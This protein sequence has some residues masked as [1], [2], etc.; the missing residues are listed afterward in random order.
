V[1]IDKI[2]VESVSIFKTKSDPPIRSEYP[3]TAENAEKSQPPR[4]G[5][6]GLPGKKRAKDGTAPV[7]S[8]L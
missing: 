2:H 5:L 6:T 4:T 7:L 3:L 1:V 8:I